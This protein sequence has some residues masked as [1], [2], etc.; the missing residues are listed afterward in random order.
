M[1]FFLK[2]P[3]QVFQD[4]NIGKPAGLDF[5]S[6]RLEGTSQNS[7]MGLCVFSFYIAPR[8]KKFIGQSK[9]QASEHGLFNHVPQTYRKHTAN[10]QQTYT[11]RCN[12]VCVDA[13]KCRSSP[14]RISPTVGLA[15]VL[16]CMQTQRMS[17]SIAVQ[18]G[19][20]ACSWR[21]H[22]TLP[23]CWTIR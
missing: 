3:L 13:T 7:I 11:K 17:Q 22:T 12:R 5:K 20:A 9:Q 8:K 18:T 10:I 4:C 15:H 19:A 2:I 14:Y 6:W 21:E 23:T 16:T 1:W